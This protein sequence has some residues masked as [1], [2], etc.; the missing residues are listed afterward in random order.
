MAVPC[1]ACGASATQGSPPMTSPTDAQVD[2]Q[3]G[4]GRQAIH[5]MMD[6]EEGGKG[7]T[8]TRQEERPSWSPGRWPCRYF[9]CV[10][11]CVA[12]G[13]DI[14]GH[15]PPSAPSAAR[16]EPSSIVTKPRPVMVVVW[17]L[18]L[19]RKHHIAQHAHAHTRSRWGASALSTPPESGSTAAR[20]GAVR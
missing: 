9:V 11:V 2:R 20:R 19:P 8:H 18:V 4:L 3:T 15:L 16:C 6:A 12:R 1:V 10:C 5:V 7:G 14:C 13:L 17:L